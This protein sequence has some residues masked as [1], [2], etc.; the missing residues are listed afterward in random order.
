MLHSAYFSFGAA[1]GGAVEAIGGIPGPERLKRTGPKRSCASA[2]QLALVPQS[3]LRRPSGIR[4]ALPF[5]A[6]FSTPLVPWDDHVALGAA[7]PTAGSPIS[8]EVVV[9]RGRAFLPSLDVPVDARSPSLVFQRWRRGLNVH[10]LALLLC[11]W[12]VSGI[13]W[14]LV[15]SE[16]ESSA[17]CY[18]GVLGRRR[19]WCSPRASARLGY[20]G[21]DSP[22]PFWETIGF[23][24]ASLSLS[25]LSLSPFL[26]RPCAPL[27][28]SSCLRR[29]VRGGRRVCCV[30]AK[31]FAASAGCVG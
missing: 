22:A 13:V 6:I 20:D 24:F 17:G 23:K 27:I 9:T 7:F 28:V 14:L 19:R 31:L 1:V 4:S 2:A 12:R 18:R 5:V 16:F 8:L 10:T 3:G 15:Y 25:P 30:A 11:V 26:R 21:W 29:L